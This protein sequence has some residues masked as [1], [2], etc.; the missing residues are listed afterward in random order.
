MMSALDSRNISNEMY[1]YLIRDAKASNDYDYIVVDVEAGY[2]ND[3][4][5]LMTMADKVILVILPDA[6]SAT[7]MQFLEQN[8]SLSDKDKY[9]CVC[10]RCKQKDGNLEQNISTMH[11]SVQEMVFESDVELKNLSQLSELVGMKALVQGI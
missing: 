4:I 6:I 7:K 3:R 11:T 2:S 1:K 10:N 5:E 8:I 9:I